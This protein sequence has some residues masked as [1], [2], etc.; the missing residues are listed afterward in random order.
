MASY[1]DSNLIKDETVQ[2][3]GELSLW[4]LAGYIVPGVLLVPLFGVGLVILLMGY[5]KY[6]TTEL[7]VTNKRVIA[8]TGF[9]SRE[10]VELNLAKTESI[11]INQSLLG[12]VFNYGSLMINGTGASHAPIAG[13]RA[14]LEFRRQFMETQD[15]ALAQR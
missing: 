1:V 10:T 3:R 6:K 14:P 13:I 4:A 11:Q 2:Y 5:I 12:R 15:K 7:A 8:K 9:I